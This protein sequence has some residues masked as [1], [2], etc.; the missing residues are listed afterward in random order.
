MRISDWSSDVCS[1]DLPDQHGTGA[2]ACPEEWRGRAI[3]IQPAGGGRPY[4]RR[5][6]RPAHAARRHHRCERQDDREGGFVS[7]MC[8]CAGCAAMHQGLGAAALPAGWDALLLPGA[9]WAFWCGGCVAAGLMESERAYRGLPRRGD[10]RM[11]DAIMAFYRPA[12]REVLVG[13]PGGQAVLPEAED[14]K[15]TRLN[16][17]H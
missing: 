8:Q 3:R 15:S 4:P 14:R 9:G 12:A 11:P 10:W 6:F 1:S 2:A 5:Q 7:D 17:S 16:S 13:F